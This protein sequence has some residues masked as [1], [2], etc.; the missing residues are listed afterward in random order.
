MS[1]HSGSY[2]LNE[3]LHLLEERGLFALMGP[4]DAQRLVLDIL[5]IS[6]QYDCNSSEILDEIGERLGICLLCLA[7]KSELIDGVCAP[8][9]K[10][11]GWESRSDEE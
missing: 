1:N 11:E 9:R 6:R 3:V 10:R 7:P 8:C 4:Q 2:M 5:K